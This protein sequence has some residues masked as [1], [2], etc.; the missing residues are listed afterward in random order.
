VQ[1]FAFTLQQVG[2]KGAAPATDPG[3]G[4]AGAPPPQ[5]SA[6][7][8]GLIMFLPLLLLVPFL[9]LSFRRQKKEQAARGSLKKGDQVVSQSGL[10]G[11][12]MEMD[13]RFAK[14]KIAPGT[15]VK[16]LAT[17]VSPLEAAKPVADDK[18]KDLKDAKTATDKK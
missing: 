9:F 6:P 15:T 2:A 8:G 7:G 17:S 1:T 14:V 5:G 13:E 3:A 10:V 12:L 16:M 18:L 4:S 11:E